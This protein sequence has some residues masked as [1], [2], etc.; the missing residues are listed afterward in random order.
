M[1]EYEEA[2][3]SYKEAGGVVVN[4]GNQSL[5]P[6][7]SAIAES[8]S[9]TLSI[10]S[11]DSHPHHTEDAAHLPSLANILDDTN[12]ENGIEINHH[13]HINGDVSKDPINDSWKSAIIPS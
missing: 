10:T 12:H 13:D 4:D 11:P 6:S 3:K 8:S 7:D 9:T 2:M 1:E 5:D